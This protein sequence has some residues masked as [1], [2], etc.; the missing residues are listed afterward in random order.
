MNEIQKIEQLLLDVDEKIE[1]AEEISRLK[2][3]NFNIF[4]IWE[5]KQRKIKHILTFLFPY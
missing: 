3:E 1:K 2:G 4:S 5:L